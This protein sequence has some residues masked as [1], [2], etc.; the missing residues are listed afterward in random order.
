M[1]NFYKKALFPIHIFQ[2][3]I[4]E[5]KLILDNLLTEI[6]TIYQNEKL[7]IPDGWLT[8]KLY[9]TFEHDTINK[10]LFGP[11]SIVH[12]Y[13]SKYVQK[14]FDEEVKVILDDIWLNVY[15]N[16]EFQEEHNH[17]AYDINMVRPY[18][19][20]IHY[21]KFDEENHEP[22]RFTDPIMEMRYNSFEMNSNNYS[23]QYKPKIRE[24]DLLM[25]PPYLKHLVPKSKPTPD[26]QRI[27][28]AF[29][30]RLL[31]Y[32]EQKHGN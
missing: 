10:A 1:N 5:N 11:D 21:L 25:F 27:T 9:T 7:E 13:Y 28:I 16:G 17:L 8:D 31:E 30:I 29:N 23:H 22:V 4:L 14:M 6:Q 20:C 26:N 3:N 15:E 24:G 2:I 18:F 32:G 12:E 19:S